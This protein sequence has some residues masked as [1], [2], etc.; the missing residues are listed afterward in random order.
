MYM[1]RRNN[2]DT[3]TSGRAVR[4]GMSRSWRCRSIVVVD[5]IPPIFQDLHDLTD[6]AKQ[7]D[8]DG[9]VVV[10]LSFVTSVVTS[11]VPG[12]LSV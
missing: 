9:V 8:G 3:H 4:L 12:S 6:L 7:M 1:D 11:E 2:P 5:R 10:E